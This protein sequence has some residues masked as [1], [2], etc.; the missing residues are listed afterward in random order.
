MS[1]HSGYYPV[2]PGPRARGEGPP[3]LLHVPPRPAELPAGEPLP[4]V[5]YHHTNTVY[6]LH[7]W[8]G[9]PRIILTYIRGLS[10]TKQ[11]RTGDIDDRLTYGLRY[12]T[13]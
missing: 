13:L 1:I 2:A 6:V 11:K 3:T 5:Q 12:S 9:E 7:I 4:K 10:P 8:Q